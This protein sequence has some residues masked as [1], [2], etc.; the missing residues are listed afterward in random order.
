MIN[1]WLLI[2]VTLLG[3][4]SCRSGEKEELQVNLI[5]ADDELTY[6]VEAIEK[7]EPNPYFYS[8]L[9]GALMR[10]GDYEEAMNQSHKA[11]KMF[12]NDQ[13]L[14]TQMAQLQLRDNNVKTAGWYLRRVPG[15]ERNNLDYLLADLEVKIRNGDSEEVNDQINLVVKEMPEN[16]A[17]YRVIARASLTQGDTT[18]AGINF[19]KALQIDKEESA[20]FGYME[21]LG[22]KGLTDSLDHEL[23]TYASM[24]SYRPEVSSEVHELCLNYGLSMQ[25]LKISHQLFG[26]DQDRDNALL[27]ANS[28]FEVKYYDSL[29]N[30]VNT[31]TEQQGADS[32]L[33]LMK[34]R[35]QDKRYQYQNALKTYR[36]IIE[37]DS[38]NVIAREE[39]RKLEN[40]IAYLR[41]LR[42]EQELEKERELT[43]IINPVKKGFE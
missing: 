36:E 6:L 22:W 41:N 34:A 23:D 8:R 14:L 35:A 27:L 9:I 5:T 33:V 42:R 26:L 28:Y 38:A 20:F 15:D 31:Y 17:V 16:A 19:H 29:I 13:V 25:A 4:I 1:K 7:T 21:Y 24:Y 3:L 40:K 39:M 32:E 18:N 11:V 30:F 2:S 10:N 12:R 43:P 37:L